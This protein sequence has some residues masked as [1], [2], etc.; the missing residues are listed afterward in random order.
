MN[1][2]T[3]VIRGSKDGVIVGRSC[4]TAQEAR[5]YEEWL[6]S[7]GFLVTV[8]HYPKTTQE[9]LWHPSTPQ[10]ELRQQLIRMGGKQD[11]NNS[12]N[13]KVVSLADVKA[14]RA[15]RDNVQY[16]PEDAAELFRTAMERNKANKERLDRKS[17]V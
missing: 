12:K 8:D 11:S 17:V 16:Q 10:E 15:Q 13:S 4:S 7:E 1:N 2:V 9:E 5:E 3:F 14:Q 6:T